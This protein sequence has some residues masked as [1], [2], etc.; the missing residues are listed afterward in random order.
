[1]VA[2]AEL[3]RY[4]QPPAPTTE[5]RRRGSMLSSGKAVLTDVPSTLTEVAPDLVEETGLRVGSQGKA[6]E[7]EAERRNSETQWRRKTAK[8]ALSLGYLSEVARCLFC[9]P[10]KLLAVSSVICWKPSPFSLLSAG[11]F[12][13]FPLL[14][15]INGIELESAKEK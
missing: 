3:Q 10:L 5:G 8:M 15:V 4:D 6:S 1:M 2:P 11:S 13:L 14:S 7:E 9:Y 12:S